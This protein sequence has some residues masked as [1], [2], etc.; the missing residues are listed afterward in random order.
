MISQ[1]LIERLTNARLVT[2]FTGAGVS[3]ESGVATFRAQGGLWSKFKP[4]EL[5]NLDAFLAKA[6][7]NELS[8]R[9]RLLKRQ[10]AKKVAEAAA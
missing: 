6:D 2:V 5:A 8:Q 3:A 7:E 10:V 1:T 4:E 9:A